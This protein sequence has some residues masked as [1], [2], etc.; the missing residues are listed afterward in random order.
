M[1]KSWKVTLDIDDDLYSRW[2]QYLI[3]IGVRSTGMG[4]AIRRANSQIFSD[5]IKSKMEKK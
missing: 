4:A 3:D 2:R 5:A 1:Q